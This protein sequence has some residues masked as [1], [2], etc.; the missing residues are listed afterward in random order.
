[1]PIDLAVTG[2]APTVLSGQYV[3]ISEGMVHAVRLTEGRAPEYRNRSIPTDATNV[4][5]FGNSTFA[6]GEGQL[7]HELGA[8]LD[9]VRRVDLAGARRTLTA[10]PT[11]DAV[12]GELHLL[13]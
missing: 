3:R 11:V 12:T 5:A 9:A 4:V 7:A 1:M 6:F 8:E 10:R 13:T 2:A